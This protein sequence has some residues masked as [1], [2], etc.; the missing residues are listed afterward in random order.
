[1]SG[2]KFALENK[3]LKVLLQKYF[4]GFLFGKITPQFPIAHNINN[5]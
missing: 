5:L 1:V 2:A 4:Q 3:A